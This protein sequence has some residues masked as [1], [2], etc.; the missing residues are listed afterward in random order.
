MTTTLIGN[1]SYTSVDP[2][3]LPNYPFVDPNLKNKLITALKVLGQEPSSKTVPLAIIGLKHFYILNGAVVTDVTDSSL[4]KPGAKPSPDTTY[5]SPL[6]IKFNL[7]PHSWSLPLNPT[8]TN[9]SIYNNN[10]KTDHTKRR[11]IM[12]YYADVKGT[13]DN[14]LG[15]VDSSLADAQKTPVDQAQYT[16]ADNYWGFQFLWNPE[17]LDTLLTR[18]SSVVPSVQDKFAAQNGLFTAMES[19]QFTITIDRINDFACL[20]GLMSSG[21]SYQGSNFVPDNVAILNSASEK[22]YTNGYPGAFQVKKDQLRDLML[23]GTMADIEYIFRMLNGSGQSDS[24]GKS[25]VW[26]NALNRVTADLSFLSPTAVAIQFGPNE[27][28]LSYVGWIDSMNIAHTVFTEDMIPIHSE[29]TVMFNAFSRV[30]LTS[31][32]L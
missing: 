11:A 19:L 13:S 31:K 9:T 10:T 17:R 28:S 14:G 21:G 30:A 20:K 12:W 1:T 32:S 16:V 2:N 6:D 22:Y 7:P 26:A 29:V 23:K 5:T 4:Q 24:S 3:K 18:N 15:A 8:I 25:L 27:N